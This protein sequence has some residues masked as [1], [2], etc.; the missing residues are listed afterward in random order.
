[1]RGRYLMTPA[2][3]VVTPAHAIADAAQLTLALS[4]GISLVIATLR[5]EPLD[6]PPGPRQRRIKPRFSV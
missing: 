5:W 1:M 6:I 4:I 2:I 3:A